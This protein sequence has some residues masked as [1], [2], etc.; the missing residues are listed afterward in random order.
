MGFRG[1]GKT[2]L[3]K[4]II[5]RLDPPK[6]F[7]VDPLNEYGEFSAQTAYDAAQC[8]D[9]FLSG[10]FPIRLAS[11]S[12]QDMALSFD[13]VR[14]IDGVF[15]V[16][17]EADF[18]LSNQHNPPAFSWVV[19]Y[20]RHFSQGILIVARRPQNLPREFTA[21]ATL[22]FQPSI[23][24]NDMNFIRG[25]IG[26]IPERLPEFSWYVSD[27][28]GKILTVDGQWVLNGIEQKD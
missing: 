27:L 9:L 14:E 13:L 22:F 2:Y 15:S 7:I 10:Q 18:F 6:L 19:N 4:A 11:A 3:T 1:S 26:Y 16:V 21:Q 25:R 24:P 5:R 23:E 28:S 8:A 12:P 17:D 20:G